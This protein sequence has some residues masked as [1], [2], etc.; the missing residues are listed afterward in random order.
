MK[1]VIK[2]TGITLGS[3]IL[4]IIL[5]LIIVPFFIDIQKFKPTIEQQVTKATGRPFTIGGDLELSL[6]PFAGIS[7]SDVHM[8]NPEGFAEKEFIYIKSFDVKVKL[9]PLLSKDVQVKRFVLTGPRIVLEKTKEG[10]ANWEGLGGAEAP[11]EEVKEQGG[12]SLPVKGLN[13]AEFRLSEGEL[14]YIDNTSGMRKEVKDLKIELMDVS[15][16]K[17]LSLM[18]SANID[19][20]PFSIE[21]EAGPIG[22]EPGKGTMIINLSVNAMGI[23]SMKLEGS[24]TDVAT[25]PQFDL[26]V[27]TTPFSPKDLIKEAI[28]DLVINTTDQEVLKT[29][30]LA[31][32]VK[33]STENISIS[34][35][36]IEL[37]Q[38]QMTF[39]A[40]AKDFQ[41]PDL[42]LKM[43]LDKIDADRYLPPVEAKGEEATR[44]AAPSETQKMTD[45]GPLRKLVMDTSVNIGELTVKGAALKDIQLQVKASDGIFN[46]DRLSIN[47]YEGS[48]SGAA[49]FDISRDIP[50]VQTDMEIK[51]LQL[52]KAIN[53]LL[54]DLVLNTKDPE[55]LKTLSARIKMKGTTENISISEGTI[56][57]DQSKMTFSAV[58]KDFQKPY[59]TFKMDLDK[60]D[61]DRYLPPAA[62]AEEE[63]SPTKIN[64]EP[65]RKIILDSSVNIGEITIK[66]IKIN[67]IQA[68]VKGKNGIFN[69]APFSLN[70]YEG[71]I[72]GN[73]A[74]DVTKDSPA[75]KAGMNIKNLQVRGLVN[76]FMKKDIIEG[77]ATGTVNISMSGDTAEL[78]KKTLNGKGELSLKNG[79]IVGIDLTG[80]VNN[81]KT[82][83]GKAEAVENTERTDFSEFI[84]PFD[85]KDGVISTQNTSLVSPVL[86][87]KA[88]GNADLPKDSLDF[89]IEP[90]FVKTLKGQGDTEERSGITVPVVVKGTFMKPKFSP[91][92]SGVAEK[93]IE[94]TIDKGIE[95]G[96]EKILDK[97]EESGTSDETKDAVKGLLKGLIG[98]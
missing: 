65:L 79:A 47:A 55:V 18:F 57:L 91:D 86:R 3:L 59:L 88:K 81:L 67:E 37:D 62:E 75:T 31:M 84:I 32:K 64:Y 93:A 53:G 94:K 52:R 42:T 9:M 82:A 22:S 97:K 73:G 14:L 21:G 92:I 5:A 8:G 98:K 69:L 23:L 66:G 72:S 33:G 7:F 17:P 38:S 46:I 76:D 50:A 71:D 89:R 48:I 80:M 12:L 28:P 10:A 13:V 29:M 56:E 61:A 41:K 16:E 35:G 36:T 39:S 27:S 77:A 24:A 58:A 4:L 45:Y 43:D 63:T 60:I 25:N 19:G 85:I 96:L 26:S 2:W 34:E 70:A 83:F 20:R 54:P 6:F 87:I 68:N 90:T 44:A 40:V 49:V 30:S 95:K 1:K 11:E 15:L 78:I 74:L 51:D